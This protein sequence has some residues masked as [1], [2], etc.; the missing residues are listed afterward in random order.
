MPFRDG[1]AVPTETLE[2]SLKAAREAQG[3]VLIHCAEG[4]SRSVSVAYMLL[5]DRGLE[6]TEALRRVRSRFGPPMRATFDSAR[7]WIQTR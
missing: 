2:S 4:R 5:R 6:H 3:P 7:V 1:E